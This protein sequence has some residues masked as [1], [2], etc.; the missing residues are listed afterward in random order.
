[1]T[2]AVG[3]TGLPDG[4]HRLGAA[5]VDVRDGRVTLAAAPGTLAGSVLTMDRAVRTLVAAGVPPAEAVTAA[6]ATPA[7]VLGRAAAGRLAPGADADLVVLDGD[8]R[9]VATVVAGRPVHDPE[10]LLGWT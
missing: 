1:V 10:G 8:L 9:A 2:D 5:P 3:A 6:T 7:G 4:R